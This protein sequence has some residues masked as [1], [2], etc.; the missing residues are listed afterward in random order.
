METKILAFPLQKF[1]LSWESFTHSLYVNINLLSLLLVHCE[2]A[3]QVKKINGEIERIAK[4]RRHVS[5]TR[6]DY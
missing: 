5:L 1:F 4:V 3:W 2:A 6:E